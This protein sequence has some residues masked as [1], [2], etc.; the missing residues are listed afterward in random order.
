MIQEGEYEA[1]AT[2]ASVGSNPKTGKP[3]INISFRILE[4]EHSGQSIKYSNNLDAAGVKYAK[5]A[6]LACGWDGRDITQAPAQ[7]VA[8][9][10]VVTIKTVI[11]Q[12]RDGKPD[13]AKVKFVGGKEKQLEPLTAAQLAEINGTTIDGDDIPF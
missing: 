10:P 13:W 7:I 8:A 6:A 2:K 5:E 9:A 3:E 4:G 1:R 12:G 11:V